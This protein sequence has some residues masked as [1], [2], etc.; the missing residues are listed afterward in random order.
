MTS[1]LRSLAR[2]K[3]FYLG[4]ICNRYIFRSLCHIQIDFID[5][6]NYARSSLDERVFQ[7]DQLLAPYLIVKTNSALNTLTL[8]IST[9]NIQHVKHSRNW[10]DN[11]IVLFR[12]TLYKLDYQATGSHP[13]YTCIC[14]SVVFYVTEVCGERWVI[15][16]LLNGNLPYN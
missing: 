10:D 3:Y 1:R 11:R 9:K 7:S 5:R 4:F 14:A 16:V 15:V 13:G 12:D 8:A 2:V 6:S